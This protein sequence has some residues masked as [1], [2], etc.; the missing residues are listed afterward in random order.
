MKGHSGGVL[1]TVHHP[2]LFSHHPTGPR[3]AL[4]RVA[5][6][7]APATADLFLPRRLCIYSSDST[8]QH[9]VCISLFRLF[10]FYYLGHMSPF[11]S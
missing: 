6:P 1:Q 3:P 5:Y 9:V 4:H 11:P 7:P 2:T 10:Y 8:L